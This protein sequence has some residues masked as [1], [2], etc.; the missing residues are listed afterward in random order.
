MWLG[1]R[2]RIGWGNRLAGVGEPLG[3]ETRSNSLLQQ[4]RTPSG[5]PGWGKKSRVLIEQKT[6][7]AE[8]QTSPDLPE[9]RAGEIDE[10]EF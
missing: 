6:F 5:K 2:G 9:R 7:P 10:L 8:G 1:E 3:R 4:V